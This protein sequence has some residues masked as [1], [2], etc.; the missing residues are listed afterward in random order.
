M[1]SANDYTVGWICALSVEAVAATVFLDERLEGPITQ[2]KN[3]TNNYKFGKIRD[4][5]V[6]IATLPKGEYGIATAASVAKD[7]TRSFPN[8]R[9]GLM[10]GIGG[11]AP[12]SKN[13]IRLGDVV[14]STPE[15]GQSGIF[16]YDYGK[17][18]QDGSFQHTRALDQPPQLLRTA[19]GSLEV[20]YEID[21]NGIEGA[22]TQILEQKPNLRRR[23][24]RPSDDT[25][26]LFR[27]GFIHTGEDSCDSCKTDQ[28]NVVSRES[29]HNE[30]TSI[31]YGMIAS[32]NTL[33]KNAILRDR[34]AAQNN[35]LCF[36]MEAAGL[37]NGFP[38]LV[39]RGI[40]D[41]SDSHKNKSWQGYAAMAAAAYAK[42]ILSIIQPPQVEDLPRLGKVEAQ[43]REIAQ[44]AQDV[45]SHQKKEDDIRILT[46][47]S[48]TDFGK[49]QTDHLR[50]WQPGTVQWLLDSPE[51]Q[52]WVQ[53]KGQIL[54]C[55][56]IPGAGKTVSASVVV[57]DLTQ[58]FS[59]DTSVG[60]VCVYC[61]YTQKDSQNTINLL[62]GI[63]KQLCQRRGSVPQ[64][65]QDLYISHQNE[66]TGPQYDGIMQALKSH[67][68]DYSQVMVVV[69]ALDEW[70]PPQDDRFNF[71]D[72]LLHMQS[73]CQ[74]NLFVTSRFVPA[75]EAKFQGYPGCQIRANQD[76]I[77][78]YIED[79]NWPLLSLIGRR[80]D[81]QQEIKS[82]VCQAANGMFL[83][84]RFYLTSLEDKTTAREIKDA[85]RTFQDR[86]ERKDHDWDLDMLA[87]AYDEVMVRIGQQG[88]NY[89]RKAHQVL[90]WLVHYTAQDYFILK[91]E[92][93]FPDVQSY[94]ANQ[95]INY[96]SL[97]KFKDGLP[98][99]ANDK[100]HWL[101]FDCNGFAVIEAN[102]RYGDYLKITP[103][104]YALYEYAAVN[105]GH[106]VRRATIST[107]NVDQAA[108]ELLHSE[109][110]INAAMKI[111]A[112][113]WGPCTFPPL[114]SVSDSKIN[115]LHLA[116]FCGLDRVIPSL[117]AT[118]E[119]NSKDSN[120]RTALSWAS[121]AGWHAVVKCLLLA[122]ADFEV[123]E[124]RGRTP[125]HFA[126]RSNRVEVVQLL[127]DAGISVDAVNADGDTA[128]HY[129]A[130]PGHVEVMQLLID[131]SISVDAVNAD[132]DTALHLAVWFNHVVVVQLLIDAGI[133]VDVA[134]ACGDTALHY[135]AQK[136]L[137]TIAHLL[138]TH[139]A[140]FDISNRNGWIYK[141]TQERLH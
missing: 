6:V 31:H 97:E 1:S 40:C 72:E 119:V 124:D 3:D 30:R 9:I 53:E 96:L 103:G 129:A 102:M 12:S 88:E 95:C 75:I 64:V 92:R 109:S 105:W 65:V 107:S 127:I 36:E 99:T 57:N 34:L 18:M 60:I 77:Y 39:I 61:S 48:S 71:V 45:R 112:G 52:K 35:V 50:K 29:R 59:S 85:L 8:V 125:L 115:G 131:A 16:Q 108:L 93:W 4:H 44:T 46:W 137:N 141:I 51:Y 23:F 26:I 130:R 58:R 55:P 126:A 114:Q 80:S 54:F 42:Q 135:T 74:V 117:M 10:V 70:Q 81:L 132:G 13:D 111:Q 91:Q 136:D 122:D 100:A 106:H 78:R 113:T 118:F 73:E 68:R 21:G 84:A 56:G 62:G 49:Q 33:M 104:W 7:L 47:L 128:L 110:K 11:G 134:N 139:G 28:A 27:A 38:C 76:D 19:V 116:A 24:G 79:Y 138:L 41:Y 17:S 2:D 86:A 89:R 14:V 133:S 66:Q 25:D 5:Y 101:P 90:S 63:L 82:C 20:D 98:V 67:L 94:L 123:V 87:E 120:G 22:I 32:A 37:I 69:D 121:E 15:K 43:I 140:R 83:L